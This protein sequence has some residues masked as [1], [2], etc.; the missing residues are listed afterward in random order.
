MTKL[1]RNITPLIIQGSH[2]NISVD[3]WKIADVFERPHKN[4]LQILDALIEDGTISRL[5][6]KPS[7]YLAR[8]KS[9]RCIELNEAGFFKAMPFIGGKKS[10]EGQRRL[11]NEFLSLRKRLDK[12]SR[13]RESI[14][15]QMVRLS[16]K[17]ARK[18][19][20][21]EIQ[22]FVDYA[23]AS[24][25]MNAGRYYAIITRAI[26]SSCLIVEPKTEQV[27]DL[28]TAIQ[29]STLQTAELIA[30]DVLVQGMKQNVSYK[31]IYQQI[32][33]GLEIFVSGRTPML[34]N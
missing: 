19:L 11:V 17:D 29:L 25:S 31:A 3:S 6:S 27:R 28:L 22:R 32:K 26:Y 14:A 2:G 20:T 24:G 21:D 16:G 8:G 10:K 15:Y 4:V 9:Y 30:A 12:Q 23:K 13:E 5:E 7:N 33:I 34:S 1:S 18:L